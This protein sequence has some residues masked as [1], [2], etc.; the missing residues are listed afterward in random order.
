MTDVAVTQTAIETLRAAVAGPVLTPDQDG[1]AAEVTGFEMVIEHAPA[2]VVGATDADD[3]V[4]TVRTAAA[5]GIPITVVGV[6]HAAIPAVTNGVLLNTSRITDV[7]L[8]PIERTARIGAG[9]TWHDVMAAAT[10]VGLAPLCGSAPGVGVAGY[11]LGG[12][13]GPIGRTV[14][15]SS[16]YVRSFEIVCADGELRT[17]SAERD[18]DL[19]WALR[20]GKG[21]FGVVT[22]VT[23]ELLDLASLYGGGELYPAAD[24]ATLLRAYQRFVNSGPPAELTTSLAILRLP[25]LP[26]LP[27]PVRGQTIAHLRI[28]YVG[29]DNAEDRAASAE[30]L[31]APLRAAVGK[32][33]LGG[34]GELPYAD[35]GTIHNDPTMP[36]AQSS[37]GALLERFE[38]ETVEAILGIG[39]PDVS[40]P[41]AAIEIR[42]LGGAFAGSSSRDAVSGREARWGLWV[43]A[44][45]LPPDFEDAQLGAEDAAVRAAIDAVAP[46]STGST[47][48]N[49]CGSA[50]TAEEAALAWPPEIADRLAAIRRRY[51]PAGLFPYVPGSRAPGARSG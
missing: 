38:P 40:T 51:D 5:A 17:V 49:M 19:F 29:G 48:I 35:L 1:Y 39:G 30:E 10:P 50:N 47:Q 23:I 11:L 9:A 21:G 46:W 45:P 16:D 27:P 28:A 6:G 4:A 34:A 13:L 12:G 20:G 25:D 43:V 26:D 8:D 36:S 22:A 37:A 32:P 31:L 3:V 15:F 24:I 14:G 18:P 2:I 42:H 7:A 44:A 41:L 33:V